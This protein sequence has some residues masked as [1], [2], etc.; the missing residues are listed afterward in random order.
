MFICNSANFEAVS[1][2]HKTAGGSQ[3]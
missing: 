1:S 2:T 3:Y